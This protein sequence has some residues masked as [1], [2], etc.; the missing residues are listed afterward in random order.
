MRLFLDTHTLEIGKGDAQGKFILPPE[1]WQAFC[2]A[3]VR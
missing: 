1:R 2:Q 3:L